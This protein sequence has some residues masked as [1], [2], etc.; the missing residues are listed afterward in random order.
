MARASYPSSPHRVPGGREY[1]RVIET[2]RN[3]ATG[4]GSGSS[5]SSG[6]PSYWVLEEDGTSL[7]ELEEGGSY[8]ILEESA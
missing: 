4:T 3:N 7:W 6:S 1:R 8:W 2:L 5:G